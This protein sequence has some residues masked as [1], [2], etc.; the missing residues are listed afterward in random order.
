MVEL[1]LMLD[2]TLSQHKPS[3]GCEVELEKG[4]TAFGLAFEDVPSFNLSNNQRFL[5]LI[6]AIDKVMILEEQV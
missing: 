5:N 4:I 1:V 2:I 3:I 6:G